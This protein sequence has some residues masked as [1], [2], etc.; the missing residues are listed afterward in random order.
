MSVIADVS[1]PAEQF[2]LGHLL[3][4]RPGVQ[5]RLESMVPT[6][7]SMVPYFWVETP[8]I[9]A[10]EEALLDSPLV[11]AV[12]I[13]DR[14]G[15]AA[16]FR[17]NWTEGIDGVVETMEMTNSVILDGS[18]HGDHWTFQIRFPDDED[19]STFY[20][21]VTDKG[22]ALELEDVHTSNELSGPPTTKLTDEQREALRIAFEE[23][24]FDIPRKITLAQLADRFGISD[25]AVSE[26]LRR[27]VTTV[28][29]ETVF[30]SE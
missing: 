2:A 8:D 25:S 3:E 24:Y 13:L 17:V 12:T 27:S 7:D 19:L 1:I 28:L 6:G 14:V 15:D 21:T 30:R 26:R 10:V 5:V 22:I 20:R 11:E 9:E 16:L 29:T 4:V 23:G 18:G